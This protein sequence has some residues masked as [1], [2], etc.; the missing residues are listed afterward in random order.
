[1]DP[2]I[3]SPVTEYSPLF[4]LRAWLRELERMRLQ[5]EENAEDTEA[6]EKFAQAR[7]DVDEW[8]QA[9]ERRQ[10]QTPKW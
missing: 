5:F 10:T 4:E 3:E 1:M 2:I 7:R 8:I 9:H 6:M